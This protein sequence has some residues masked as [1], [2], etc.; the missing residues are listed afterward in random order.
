MTTY[1]GTGNLE[2]MADAVNYNAFLL[3][4][5][6]SQAQQG[7]NILDVG[8]GIGTF[9]IA[10]AREGFRVACV[11]PDPEQARVIA[12]AGLPVARSMPQ[13][14]DGSVDY[15]YALNVLEHIED[16]VAALAEWRTKLKPGAALLVY[17]P[18]FQRLY[19]SMDRRVGHCRRY[20]RS[21][22]SRLLESA[23]FD[24]LRTRYA[25]SAGF[26]ASL[27]FKALGNDS[28]IPDRRALI[29]YDRAVFPASRFADHLLG[30]FFGKNVMAIARRPAE[31]LAPPR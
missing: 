15:L 11:E 22:L 10:L 8:A 29:L 24:V 12:A 26:F 3:D 19:S 4:L 18:A 23:G 30:A 1:S 31:P 13:V 5:V 28:G 6:R 21:E 14:A 25:D 17:V 2:L 7:Q 27:L 20:R 9:A 16:D